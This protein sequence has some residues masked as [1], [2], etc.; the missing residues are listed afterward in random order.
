MRTAAASAVATDA[1]A[2]PDA[3]RLAIFGCG[4]QARSHILAIQQVRQ[5]DEIVVWGRNQKV[6]AHFVEKMKMETTVPIRSEADAETAAAQ[7]DIICTVTGSNTP[8]LLG[9]WVRPGTHVNAIG[10]SLAGLG[11]VDAA[12][13]LASRY[14]VDSRRAAL[15]AAVEFLNAKAAGLLDDQHI[16]AEIGDVLL[17]HIT[18]RNTPQ[19]ITFYKSLGHIVQD[20]ATLAYIQSKT[21][22]K[23]TTSAPA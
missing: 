19:E 12:L 23:G 16:V 5:L 7:A 15:V 20:L 14:I 18:G 2:R 8:V 22:A 17:G 13:V 9:A 6:S 21:D 4:T 11:E 10:S 1:L 3:R